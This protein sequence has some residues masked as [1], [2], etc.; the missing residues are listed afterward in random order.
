MR[1]EGR[2][3]KIESTAKTG[4]RA[5]RDFIIFLGDEGRFLDAARLPGII[6]A[7]ST[8]S[9]GGVRVMAWVD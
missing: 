9:K 6:I 8:I 1:F 3:S 4:R 2:I 7:E 5:G